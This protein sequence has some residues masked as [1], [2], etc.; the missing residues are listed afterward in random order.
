MMTLRPTFSIRSSLGGVALIAVGLAVAMAI[1]RWND[2]SA[3]YIRTHDASSLDV[4]FR[5]RIKN[6][7]RIEHVESMLGPCKRVPSGLRTFYLNNA[8]RRPSEHPQ[9]GEDRDKFI[10]YKAGA[11]NVVLQ[12]RDGRLVNFNPTIAA[13]LKN[14]AILSR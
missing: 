8:R 10:A 11:W 5:S 4:V 9:G 3:R 12:I 14:A 2:P 1:V 13:G 6:G 7:D